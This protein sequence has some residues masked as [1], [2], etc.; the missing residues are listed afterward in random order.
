MFRFYLDFLGVGLNKNKFISVNKKTD[1]IPRDPSRR[2][3]PQNEVIF[4]DKI[5]GD[6]TSRN[7]NQMLINR[8]NKVVCT[9]DID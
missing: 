9:H 7:I 1:F 8:L 3:I 2:T 5:F 6:T 4:S